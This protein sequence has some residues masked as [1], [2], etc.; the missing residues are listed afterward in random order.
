MPFT[1]YLKL[2]EKISIFV[3][4]FFLS[5]VYTCMFALYI[6]RILYLN[7]PLLESF[8]PC[9]R[10]R[11]PIPRHTQVLN[12]P[13]TINSQH[14][15]TKRQEQVAFKTLML[16][17]EPGIDARGYSARARATRARCRPDRFDP[18]SPMSVRKPFTACSQG[19]PR[20]GPGGTQTLP[21]RR[22]LSSHAT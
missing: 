6:S 3:F 2:I 9:S 19:L 5:T 17:L 8:A 1:K 10:S 18:P 7:H 21:R 14:Y 12:I 20:T 22:S 13:R 16:N 15:E 11:P 4:Y